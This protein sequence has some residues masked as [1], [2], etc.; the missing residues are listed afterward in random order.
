[1]TTRTFCFAVALVVCLT[2]LARGQAGAV[3]LPSFSSFGV[4]TEVSAPDSGGAF[5]G[6]VGRAS[7]GSKAFG[8]ALG[9]RRAFGQNRSS[10]SCRVKATVHDFAAHDEGGEE[11]GGKDSA[12]TRQ[13]RRVSK[14]GESSAGKAPPG[15]LAEARRKHAAEMAARDADAEELIAKAHKALDQGKINV[16]KMYCKMAARDAS[17]DMK[18]KIR[19]EIDALP[20]ATES[21]KLASSSSR[22]SGSK[23][24]EQSTGKASD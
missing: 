7:S 19:R 15:S 1:M 12:E 20:A 6:G 16:A 9:P 18:R 5:I 23:S 10:S 13:S 22:R 4:Q 14:A 17:D 21:S 24:S 3:Q 8:P 11:V 2:S